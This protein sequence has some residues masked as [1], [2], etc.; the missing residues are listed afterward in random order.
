[1]G[2]VVENLFDGKWEQQDPVELFEFLMEFL[3]EYLR[4]KKG[5]VKE[6][7]YGELGEEMEDGERKYRIEE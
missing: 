1:M 3:E 2:F 4:R 7:R 5:E 6:V